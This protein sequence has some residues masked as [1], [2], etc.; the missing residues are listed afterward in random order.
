MGEGGG[1]DVS[2]LLVSLGEWVDVA[3]VHNLHTCI[4]F[5]TL[6]ARAI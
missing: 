2:R 6:F 4:L 1:E 3:Q 5:C